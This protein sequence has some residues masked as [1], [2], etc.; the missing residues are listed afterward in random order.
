[1]N[2]EVTKS[3]EE[4]SVSFSLT[5]K[6]MTLF[7]K[8]REGRNKKRKK[9]RSTLEGGEGTHVKMVRRRLSEDLSPSKAMTGE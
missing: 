7:I 6:K 9:G 8:D 4:D 2:K 3:S 5:D 1:M